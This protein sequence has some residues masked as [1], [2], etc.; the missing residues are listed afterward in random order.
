MSPSDRTEGWAE[1]RWVAIGVL[2]AASLL[3]VQVAAG[4]VRVT[5]S[6]EPSYLEKLETCL[7]ERERPFERDVQDPIASSAERGALRTNAEGNP[8]T[9]ALGSSEKDA[10]RVYQAYVMVASRDVVETRLERHR[11]VVLLWDFEPSPSQ[12]EFMFL[13]TQDAQE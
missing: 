11:K 9:V 13:C 12:R 8:V 2:V 4:L 1:R 5:V 6:P 3:A 10:E 7:L